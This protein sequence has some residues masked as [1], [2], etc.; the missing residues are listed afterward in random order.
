[1][2][3]TK[4]LILISVLS[5]LAAVCATVGVSF[6]YFSA[7]N[8]NTSAV[9]TAIEGT[10]LVSKVSDFGGL[11]QV[12]KS[13]YYNDGEIVSST[14]YNRK[15]VRLT[16]D[17]TL[18]NDILITADVHIDLNGYALNLNG[19]T[20]TIQHAYA[21]TFLLYDGSAASSGRI[22]SYANS[23]ANAVYSA[24]NIVVDTINAVVINNAVIDSNN[25]DDAAITVTD[26]NDN[27]ATGYIAYSVLYTVGEALASSAEKRPERLTYPEFDGVTI[28]S[29]LFVAQKSHTATATSEACVYVAVDNDLVLPTHYLSTDYKIVYTTTNASVFSALG[30]AKAKGDAVLTVSVYDGETTLASVDFTVHVVESGDSTAAE[31]LLKCYLSDYYDSANDTYEF[32]GGFQLPSGDSDLGI[33][34]SG[35]NF[36]S[37][38]NSETGTGTIVSTASSAGDGVYELIPTSACKYLTVTD[39][40]GAVIGPLKISSVYVTDNEAVAQ[41]I[42]NAFY[43]GSIVYNPTDSTK[44]RLYDLTDITD[45]NGEFSEWNDYVTTYGVKGITCKITGEASSYYTISTS[46]GKNYLELSSSKNTPASNVGSV[47]YTITFDDGSSEV[48]NLNVLY[49]ASGDGMNAYVGY[50]NQ[51]NAAVVSSVSS[52]FTLTF[53]STDKLAYTAYE[54]TYNPSGTENY[55][56]LQGTDNSGIDFDYYEVSACA[57]PTAMTLKLVKDVTKDSD[58]R[59]TVYTQYEGAEFAY[60]DTTTSLVAA[61][62]SWLEESTYT[63]AS[64]SEEGAVWLVEIDPTKMIYDDTEVLILYNYEFVG[65]ASTWTAYQQEYTTVGEDGATTDG[66]FYT[67]STVTEFTLVGGVYY[68]ED[69]S[70]D[71][72]IPDKNLFVWMSNT[73]DGT[74]LTA[75]DELNGDDLFIERTALEQS[76][77]LDVTVDSI[78]MGVGDNWKGI[79]YLTGLTEANLSG[80]TLDYSILSQFQAVQKLTLQNCALTEDSFVDGTSYLNLPNLKELDVRNNNIATFDWL[81]VDNFPKLEKVHITGNEHSDGYTGNTGM[82]NYQNFED[83]NGNGVTVYNT[84]NA[85]GVEIPFAEST[86]LND[87]RRLKSLVYQAILPN[88]VSVKTV[89]RE[90][91]G[92][93]AD[94]SA[95]GDYSGLTTSHFN[96]EGSYKQIDASSWGYGGGTDEYDATYFSLTVATSAGNYTLTVKFYVDRWQTSGSASSESAS[97]ESLSAATTLSVSDTE[98]VAVTVAANGNLEVTV[99]AQTA[100][101]YTISVEAA[102]GSAVSGLAVSVGSGEAQSFASGSATITLAEGTNTVTIANSGTT[103]LSVTLK[104]TAANTNGDEQ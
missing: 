85:A 37:T 27:N 46:N 29:E 102:D 32:A 26:V 24:A 64:L 93:N 78:L 10:D 90:F 40:K 62:N 77:T 103:E 34:Y 36:Y 30:N 25:T 47:Q 101:D 98:G 23:A 11:Y 43:G 13:S 61:F 74:E 14:S 99:T 5:V 59:V 86:E 39:D 88:G 87:Y 16:S 72:A 31:V 89:Y 51:Y 48:I 69:S 71:N 60:S 56:T 70:D 50:Y 97:E 65:S 38:Y 8:S 3:K 96:L 94:L 68:S 95:P 35:Y 84:T 53:S 80:V 76:A 17:I 45:S 91:A 2:N 6:A 55:S 19:Y 42:L 83:L 82:S 33:A 4:R 20:L 67:E 28:S 44:N 52:S 63:L 15:I 9:V 41:V 54:F 104:L 1:M 58:G 49:T 18:A 7:N 73:F 22:V 12:T 75:D 100:G 57:M 21:G 79:E 81:T 66:L 92:L